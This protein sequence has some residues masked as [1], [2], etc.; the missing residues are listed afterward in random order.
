VIS[1]EVRLPEDG[2]WFAALA[3][4]VRVDAPERSAGPDAGRQ[5]APAGSLVLSTFREMPSGTAVIL[6]LSLPDGPITIDGV[7]VEQGGGSGA[8]TLRIAFAAL[9]D[10]AHDRIRALYPTAAFT[11][12]GAPSH[13]DLASSGA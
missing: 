4:S 9:P 7:V 3:T 5:E 12:E 2:T 6:Q 13:H 11:R 8:P 1:V 10:E